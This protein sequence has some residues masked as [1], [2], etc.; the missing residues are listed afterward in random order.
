MIRSTAKGY[1]IS[2]A[3]NSEYVLD[4]Q[5]AIFKNGSKIQLCS[6]KNNPAQL[7]NLNNLD[8]KANAIN[9]LAAA[10]VKTIADG[11]YSISSNINKNGSMA[12][13]MGQ[14]R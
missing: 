13:S 12:L 8:T 3:W 1:I 2:S 11:I 10:N 14:I 7:W 6:C 5:G 9:E 4:V